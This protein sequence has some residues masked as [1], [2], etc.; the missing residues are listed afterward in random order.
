MVTLLNAATQPK[1]LSAILAGIDL[2][3][4]GRPSGNVPANFVDALRARKS[5]TVGDGLSRILIRLGDASER[6]AVLSTVADAQQPEAKRLAGLQLLTQVKAPELPARLP[7]WLAE[8]KSDSWRLAI[9]NALEGIDDP[10]T[11]ERVL[12]AYPRWSA[13]V[14]RRA[15]ALLTSRPTWTLALL[16]AVDS[17]Q[18]PKTEL[19]L[20]QIRPAAGLNHSQ[21]TK[22]IEKHWGKVGPATAGEKQAR[23][24]YLNLIMNREGLGDQARG[25]ALFAKHCAACHQLFGE[26]G[27]VGPDLT[28]ADRKNRGYLLTHIIDPSLYIRPEFLNYKIDTVDGRTLTG[29]VTEQGESVT[30][31]SVV[32]NQVQAIV[33]PK[34]DIDGILPSKVSLMPEK[35][36]D[37]ISNDEVRDLFAYL[38]A[39]PVNPAPGGAKSQASPAPRFSSARTAD[40]T[41]AKQRYRVALISGSLEYKSDES[42]AKFQ[43]FLESR[44]PIQCV[45]IF[46]KTDQDLPGL[47]ALEQ[48]D[49]AIFYTRRL[50]IQGDQLDRIKAYVASGKPILGLRT[51]SHGFQNWLEM[52]RLAFG[53]N[54]QG[55]YQAGP[56]CEVT[57]AET[58][59]S[60]PILAGVKPFASPGSLYKNPGLA[61][62]VQVLLTGRIPGHVEPVAWVRERKLAGKTQRVVYTSLGYRDDFERPEFRRFLVNA[63]FW[64]LGQPVPTEK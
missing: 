41:T 48:C 1:E 21:V 51:A 18:F 60:H 17:N 39:N 64:C 13:T 27:K 26:G 54:Y 28:T 59:K 46:R 16:Q 23:I 58:G 33:I 22:L 36:L 37:S 8:A 14:K 2:A 5:P 50:T 45:R 43:Q 19:T 30:V 55:H 11:A 15:V 47:E 24:A 25:K 44:Y 7:H 10:A 34:A 31:T 4:Q 52:D 6:L 9:L 35:I 12:A 63:L 62:D 29:L 53:G 20:D 38:M 32:N 57:I 40:T 49:L 61:D 3:L 42:L 56:I